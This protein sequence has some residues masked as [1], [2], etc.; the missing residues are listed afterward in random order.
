MRD[1]LER[2]A[3]IPV[4]VLDR[5]ADAAPLAET[6]VAGGLDV[7]EVTLRTPAALEGLSAMRAAVPG[8]V[9]G[10]GTVNTPAQ[11][12]AAAAAGAMFAVSP[13]AT[14]GLLEAAQKHGLPYLPGAATASEVLTLVE[15]G[16]DALKFFPA[17]AAGGVRMLKSW[18]AP[19][20][21]VRFCPTG[22]V[23]VTNAPEYLALDNVACVGGSWITP[24]EAVA[25]RDWAA[26]QGMAR[27]A[28]HLGRG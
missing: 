24:R 21:H 27:Q 13:G 3:V 14:A 16:Y 6:L 28:A 23:T 19:L 8:A 1:L 20:A 26:I 9:I 11:M 18:A 12:A 22:G 4:L 10:A 17:E 15:H 25:A 7:L 5:V 2:N